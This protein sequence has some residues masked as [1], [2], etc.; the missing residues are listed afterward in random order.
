MPGSHRSIGCTCH[1][2]RSGRARGCRRGAQDALASPGELDVHHRLSNLP[3][4]KRVRRRVPWRAQ[5]VRFGGG[6]TMRLPVSTS[7]WLRGWQGLEDAIKDAL[8]RR[9]RSPAAILDSGLQP[10]PIGAEIGTGERRCGKA[11]V[12]SGGECLRAPVSARAI[13]DAVGPGAPEDARPGSGEDAD[14]VRVVAASGPGAA[15]DGGGPGALVPGVVGHAGERGAP[16]PV[17][18]LSATPSRTG[19][20]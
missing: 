19:T 7:L 12:V 17:L 4:H 8:R 20:R 13:R 18:R 14:G 6:R 10:Q 2:T 16:A 9:R 3:V 5:A 1:L 15:V 11:A